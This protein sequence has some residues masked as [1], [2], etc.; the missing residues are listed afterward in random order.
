MLPNVMPMAVS[1]LLLRSER[2][3][4]VIPLRCTRRAARKD[5]LYRFLDIYRVPVV[6]VPDRVLAVRLQLQPPLDH[7]QG[8]FIFRVQRCIQRVIL[9]ALDLFKSIRQPI[10]FPEPLHHVIIII[11][12]LFVHQMVRPCEKADFTLH[13]FIIHAKKNTER[14][15][16]WTELT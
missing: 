3:D 5:F 1:S 12:P 14:K 2:I 13:I 4:R 7:Q 6:P 15:V 8:G 10:P 16:R 11:P 9:P